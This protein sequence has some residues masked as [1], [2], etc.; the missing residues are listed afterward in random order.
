MY[1]SSFSIKL[2]Q[3]TIDLY[4]KLENPSIQNEKIY[5]LALIRTN[6]ANKIINI[7]KEYKIY[8]KEKYNTMIQYIHQKKIFQ[9]FIQSKAF[10]DVENNNL[11]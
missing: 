3:N 7:L 4:N 9:N 6:N 8:K 1:H 11:K 10:I 2:Y 5:F